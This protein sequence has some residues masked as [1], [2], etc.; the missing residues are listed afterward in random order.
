MPGKRDFIVVDDDNGHRITLQKR[1][2]L[3]SIREAYQLFLA[4]NQNTNINLSATSFSE[5][6]PMHALVQS[7]M[8]H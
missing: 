5:L 1:I 7:S 4:E 8:P 6:R 3:F 2:I